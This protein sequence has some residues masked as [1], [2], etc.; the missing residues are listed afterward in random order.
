M[1]R[2]PLFSKTLMIGL[3]TLLLLIPLGMIE[4]KISERKYLQTQVQQDIARSAS[5]PQTMAGP[6]LVI[7]YKV[8]ERTTRLDEKGQEKIFVSEAGPYETVIAPHKLDIEG[9]ADVEARNR[10]IYQARLYNLRSRVSGRFDVPVGY[11][12]GK[13]IDD[14]IPQAAYLVVNVSD[15]RGIRNAPALTLNG[16]KL[17]FAPGSIK[18]LAGNGM[19]VPL[20]TLTAQVEHH[21]DFSFPLDLQ[22]MSTLAIN[23]S[24]NQTVM[25]LKS[26]W[27]HP[28]FGGSYLP[29]QRQIDDTGFSASWLVTNLARNN[30]TQSG[31]TT[32]AGGDQFS[33]EFIDPINVYLLS[34]RAVKYGVMFVV[35]IFTAFFMFEVLKNLRIHPMQY[36]LVGLAMAMFFL[37]IISLSE[38]IPF[39]VAYVASGAACVALIGVYLAGVLG[40]RKPAMAFSGSIALLYAVLYGVLQ[41]E[42]N[43]L[44][45]GTVLMFMALAGV[46]VLTR[47][48]DWYRLSEPADTQAV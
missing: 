33:V 48:M 46:M 3:L 2:F 13:P 41:S 10:G 24:G 39:W 15:S 6:Y 8:R 36:L 1:K 42:D 22:G 30:T 38:H 44:L 43:A 5:G 18:P 27:P 45:M 35:L 34:E 14:I 16:H 20:E 40:N 26:S 12:I 47:K 37:L 17:E 29:R 28:S 11:G 32:P 23:P 31:A 9:S 21:F 7:H 19:H 25:T 4:S